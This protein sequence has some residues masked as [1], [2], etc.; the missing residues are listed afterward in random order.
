LTFYL[1]RLFLGHDITVESFG[2]IIRGKLIYCRNSERNPHRPE[3]LILE[4]LKGRMI[5][6]RAWNVI[7]I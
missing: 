4:G 5:I 6:V 1:P 3:V 7:K 2:Y